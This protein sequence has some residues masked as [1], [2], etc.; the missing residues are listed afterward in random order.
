MQAGRNVSGG[1]E[2]GRNVQSVLEVLVDL[3]DCC[4]VP[5]AVAIVRRREDSDHVTIVRPVAARPSARVQQRGRHAQS[6]HDELVS[7]R[8]QRKTVV[9]VERFA[10]VLPERVPRPTGRDPPAAAVVRV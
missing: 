10:D 6:L 4:L 8:D 1:Q 3:H 7:P 2:A 9:V 5:T